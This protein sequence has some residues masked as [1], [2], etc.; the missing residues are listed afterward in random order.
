MTRIG[1]TPTLDL[2]IPQGSDFTFVVT[3]LGGPDNLSGYSG[4]LQMRDTLDG[5]VLAD[6]TDQITIDPDNRQVVVAMEAAETAEWDWDY[7]AAVYDLFIVSGAS[8]LR[9]VQGKVSVKASVTREA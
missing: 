6:L 2:D 4:H 5:E 3:V 8:R 9:I 1:T 7:P